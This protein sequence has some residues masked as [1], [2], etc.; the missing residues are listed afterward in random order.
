MH[1]ILIHMKLTVSLILMVRVDDDKYVH[2]LFG[3]SDGNE[4]L[5]FHT[6]VFICMRILKNRMWD[7]KYALPKCLN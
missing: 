2:S 3:G 1:I 5:S 4:Y 7:P 6:C